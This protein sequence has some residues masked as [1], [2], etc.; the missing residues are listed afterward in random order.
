MR[1]C[2]IITLHSL[3]CVTVCFAGCRMLHDHLF[4]SISNDWAARRNFTRSPWM[5]IAKK[6]QYC[7]DSRNCSST[8]NSHND[9]DD[10]DCLSILPQATM[11]EA[12]EGVYL[13]DVETLHAEF[14]IN[15]CS[16]AAAYAYI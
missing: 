9:D 5:P 13:Q 8:N 6:V 4:G 15:V 1:P 7:S 3:N 11:Q 14:K 16:C 12:H 10:D 2:H